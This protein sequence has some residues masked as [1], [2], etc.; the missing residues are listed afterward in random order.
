MIIIFAIKLQTKRL[1][2][3][4]ESHSFTLLSVIFE[5]FVQKGIHCTTK[6]FLLHNNVKK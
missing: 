1:Q 6:R 5:L 2:H 3:N 4:F